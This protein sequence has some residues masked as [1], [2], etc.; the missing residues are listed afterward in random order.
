MFPRLFLY[1]LHR[2]IGLS[3]KEISER[4]KDMFGFTILP[5]GVRNYLK[6]YGLFR[7]RTRG[8]GSKTQTTENKELTSL[9]EKCRSF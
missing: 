1:K 9:L 5:H 6:A 7:P 3:P 2:V 8:K 4:H